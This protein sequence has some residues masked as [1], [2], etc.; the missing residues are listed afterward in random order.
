MGKKVGSVRGW[1]VPKYKEVA[2]ST[3]KNAKKKW[4]YFKLNISYNNILTRNIYLLI[5]VMLLKLISM[6]IL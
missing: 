4:L 1:L 6:F 3:V 5:D 2:T